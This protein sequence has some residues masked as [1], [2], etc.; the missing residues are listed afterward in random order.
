MAKESHAEGDMSSEPSA[1]EA[2]LEARRLDDMTRYVR[3]TAADEAL[4]RAFHAI[5]AP[6]F[7]RIAQEFYDRIREHEEAHAVFTGEEQ[8]ARL[9]RSL[10]RWL[11]RLC[12]GAR[13]A[14]YHQET[15]KIGLVHVKVGVPQRYVLTAMALIRIEL[16]RLTS[17][18][19]DAAEA[20]REALLKATDVELAIMLDTYHGEAI[21]RIERMERLQRESLGRALARSEHRYVNAVELAPYMVVGIDAERRI[22]LANREAERVTAYARDE[23]LGRPFVETMVAEELRPEQERIVRDV[24]EGHRASSPVFDSAVRTR[25]GNVRRLRWQLAHAPSRSGNEAAEVD[26]VVVFAIG[27]DVTDEIALADR[28]R[29]AE[30]LAAVGTLAAGLA[31]EIRN[32]LNGALLH[33]TFLERGLLRAGAEPETLEA[34]RVV[35]GEI[36]RLSQ[37]VSEFLDFARPQPLTR[38]PVAVQTVCERAAQLVEADATAAHVTVIRDLPRADLVVDADAAKLEQVLLNLV[39]NAIEA[40]APIGGGEVVIRARRTPLHAILEVE[41]HGP[42]LQN[43]HAPIFDAFYSTKPNGTGLGLAIVH[44]IINDH[45]GTIAVES[46]PGRVVFRATLPIATTGEPPNSKRTS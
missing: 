12:T 27:R 23:M 28:T 6:H 4:L 9:Q 30:K 35:G 24:A 11:D 29:Q 39:R 1:S 19:G 22:L 45:G 15:A 8:I 43:A 37:L 33:V 3:F 18:L 40:M 26:D 41:D 31:H 13:D 36:D 34:L 14:R 42:G 16:E 32:P 46:E 38:Q 7:P 21:Q 5:A 2:S 17:Q 25:S 20:T 10:V 44:R